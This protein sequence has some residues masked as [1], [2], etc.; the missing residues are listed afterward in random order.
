MRKIKNELNLWG[1]NSISSFKSNILDET[2]NRMLL[3]V[4]FINLIIISPRFIDGLPLGIDSTSHL[5]KILFMYKSFYN[6]GHIPNWNPD[7]YCG[8]PFLL[9]YPPLSYFMVFFL[10]L[11]TQNPILS[12]KI[13]DAFFYLIA[14]FSLYFLAREFNFTKKES[15]LAAVIYSLSPIVIGNY[16]FYDRFPNIIAIPLTCFLITF[17]HRIFNKK[18]NIKLLAISSLF[19]AGI[20]LIHHLSAL[21]VILIIFILIFTFSWSEKKY[22]KKLSIIFLVFLFSFLLTSFWATPFL[23]T[24]PTHIASNPFYNRTIDFPYIRLSYFL[25]NLLTR[26]IGLAHFSIAIASLILIHNKIFNLKRKIGKIVVFMIPLFTGMG[27]FEWAEKYNYNIL[28][29]F[30]QSLVAFSFILILSI[31][32]IESKKKLLNASRSFFIIWFIFFLWLGLGYFAFPLVRLPGLASIWRS[33]DIFRFW[34]Y[35][36][37]PSSI[38]GGFVLNHILSKRKN[39]YKIIIA[40]IILL[41]ISGAF[42]KSGYSLT[43]QI[44]AQLPY[45]TSNSEIPSELIDYFSSKEDEGRILAIRCPL[46]IYVLPHYTDKSLIDGWYP[47]EKLLPTLLNINDY[48]IND[49]ET[50]ENRTDIWR[51]LIQKH[52]SFGIRW[53]MIGNINQ[54]LTFEL[55]NSSDF[56]KDLEVYYKDWKIIV[57]EADNKIEIAETIPKNT[58]DYTKYSR[59]A[60]D[61]IKIELKNLKDDG[62]LIIKEAHYHTWAATSEGRELIVERSNLNEIEEGFIKIAIQKDTISIDLFQKTGTNY[63]VYISIFSFLIILALLIIPCRK[64]QNLKFSR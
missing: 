4:F 18:S 15:S 43:Q 17:L 13:I 38:L 58:S 53:V 62:L 14:P 26:E 59:I 46:W 56:S 24:A 19:L 35:L 10:S 21:Y 48:R 47:Q 45:N 64:F 52:N 54:S 20:V 5:C 6:F 55:M 60:P 16:L 1:N 30:S 2:E 11:I 63:F 39:I 44:N 8:T 41:M 42:I 12:Y 57:F 61:H 40:L 23:F 50:S 27:I 9:L 7:W 32:L 28:N 22:I 49:L 34:L 3:L 29:V 51:S 37:I 36:V 33:L 25:D 31:I